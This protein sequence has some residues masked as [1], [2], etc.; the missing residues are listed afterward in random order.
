[1]KKIIFIKFSLMLCFIIIGTLFSFAQKY[2]AEDATRGGGAEFHNEDPGYSGTGFVRNFSSVGQYVQ[3]SI[4]GATAGNQDLYLRYTTGSAGSLHLYVNGVMIRKITVPTTGGW[5][6][7]RDHLE[8]VTLNAGNNTIKFQHDA[9][10][11][12]MYYIDC[13]TLAE[14]TPQTDENKVVFMGNSIT[15][16]WSSTHPA[17]F[18]GKPYVNKG[19]SGQTTSQ[20]LSRFTND[21]VKLDPAVVVILG[22]TNDI[23]GNG[24]PTTVKKIMANIASMAQLAKTNGI[25]VVLC[26]V[27]P[28]LGYNWRPEV[29]PVDSIISLNSLIKTYTQENEMIYADFYSALVNEQKGMKSGY[30]NDGVHPNMAGY[31]V[32]EPIVEEAIDKAIALAGMN[33]VYGTDK[34]FEVFP[35]PIS[36]GALSI[37]LPEGVVKISI[38]DVASK[39]VYQKMVKQK[40]YLIDNRIFKANGIYMVNVFTSERSLSKKIVVSK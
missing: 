11:T 16:F 31:E 25:K 10:D 15:E 13:L 39:V 6:N 34:D 19:I 24:G 37:K 17:F 38:S 40:Q 27:L 30:S 9:D 22:G 8:N 14:S 29:K 1:M 26:S 7:W 33:P 5:S 4:T 21:V 28:V 12:G 18:N 36:G 23:A 35:N 2:E 32:M 3:F 20:M